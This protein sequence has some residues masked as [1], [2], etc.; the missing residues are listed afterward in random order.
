MTH[1]VDQKK[2]RRK[3]LELTHETNSAHVASNLSIV[4]ILLVIYKN[5]VKKKNKNEFI[6]SKG[7]ACLS[8]YVILNFFGYISDRKLK[9]FGKNNTELMSHISHKVPGVVFS[10]GSLGHGLPFSVGKAFIN[11]QKKFYCLISDGEI[12]EGSNWEAFMFASHHKLSNL[13]IIIDC[14]KIQSLDYVK[15]VID[16][17]PLEDKFKCFGFYVSRIDGHNHNKLKNTLRI[18]NKK[19]HII[20]ADTIKGKGVKFMQNSVLWHYKPPN[21][22]QLDEATKKL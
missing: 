2:I 12:N 14:N 6:L 15:N 16:L 9:T 8:Y 13:K 5:F 20:I 17:E 10:T 3:I 4:D 1:I 18:K 7:H 19:P 22:M 21:K 11:K